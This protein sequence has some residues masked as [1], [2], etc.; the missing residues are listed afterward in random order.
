MSMATPPERQN[1]VTTPPVAPD[2]TRRP[3]TAVQLDQGALDAVIAGV[4]AQLR[5]RPPEAIAAA[6]NQ[7]DNHNNQEDPPAVRGEFLR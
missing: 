5:A 4:T 2:G 3:V 6:N 7:E 1:T